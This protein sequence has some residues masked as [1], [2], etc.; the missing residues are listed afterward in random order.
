[1][2]TKR[3]TFIGG[4]NMAEALVSG[5]IQAG[6]DAANITITDA[7]ASKLA[8]L[9]ASYGVTTSQDNNAAITHA[10]VIVLAVKPQVIGNVLADIGAN[11]SLSTTVVSIAAGASV[12]TLKEAAKRDDIAIVRVMPNTPAMLG[13]GM[14]V[15][16]SDERQTHK[17]NAEYIL[18]ASGETA[19]VADEKELHAVTA[20]S[21]SGP[22]YFFLLAEAMQA[23][24]ESL[25]LSKDLAAKL[26]NQTALGAGRMLAESG[27]DAET[28]RRQVTSPGGT[29]Q[30][31]LDTMYEEE[32]PI[33]V[34]KAI[35]AAAKRSRELS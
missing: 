18:A 21:G 33:T 10:D 16:F 2:K 31:A 28:L 30:A 19:W 26:A 9:V 20:L 3:I 17:D 15:L 22:A 12:Q 7:D 6:H 8:A 11:I 1:M 32:L 23:A 5:L 27:R 4:G 24:G 34:R 35:Q 25:G 29:T 14:S 13:A